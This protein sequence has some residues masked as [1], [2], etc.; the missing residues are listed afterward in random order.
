MDTPILPTAGIMQLGLAAGWAL[1]LAWLV[2]ALLQWF[3]AKPMARV[4]RVW[5][6]W[7]A[8]ATMLVCWL[9]GAW[10][11]AFH[12]GLAFQTP[13]VMS[14]VLCA[15]ALWRWLVV[16]PAVSHPVPS[17][18]QAAAQQAAVLGA[19][20]VGIVLGWILLLDTLALVRGTVYAW[21]YG[22]YALWALLVLALGWTLLL[23]W[24][25]QAS[26]LRFA[27]PLFL[28]LLVFAA[29]R[30][31]TGNVW[32]ALLDPWLWVAL[33][34]LAWQQLKPMLRSLRAVALQ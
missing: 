12:L 22:R 23:R 10:S 15:M 1:L 27:L 30:L 32:D 21:G 16:Q 26:V 29:T 20:L 3:S 17:A 9:P 14:L 24:V 2:V 34:V 11:P 25:L 13:S 31:T 4:R 7:L 19:A 5:A 18:A 28:V 6:A 8:L 33:H